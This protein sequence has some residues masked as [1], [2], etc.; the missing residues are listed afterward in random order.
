MGAL[1]R[2]DGRAW[3]LDIVMIGAHHEEDPLAIFLVAGH[4]AALHPPRQ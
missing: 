4:S 2:R 3:T 1:V